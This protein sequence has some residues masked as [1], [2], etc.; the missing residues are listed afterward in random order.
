MPT[1]SRLENEVDKTMPQRINEILNALCENRLRSLDLADVGFPGMDVGQVENAPKPALFRGRPTGHVVYPSM[2]THLA[3]SPSGRYVVSAIDSSHS[4]EIASERAKICLWDVNTAQCLKILKGHSVH[5]WGADGSWITFLPN[6]K[7]AFASGRRSITVWDLNDEHLESIPEDTDPVLPISGPT[8]SAF[9]L[10]ILPDG[11]LASGM[12]SGSIYI[13][14]VNSH[15]HV[16]TLGYRPVYVHPQGAFTPLPTPTAITALVVLPNNKLVSGSYDALIRVWDIPLGQ[17]ERV[18]TGH[19]GYINSLALLSNEQLA[20]ASHD[21]TVR[22]WDMKSGQCIHTSSGHT[23]A[24]QSIVA[25]PNARLLSTSYDKTFRVWDTTTGECLQ[26]TSYKGVSGGCQIALLPDGRFVSDSLV[27][28]PSISPHIPIICIWPEVSLFYAAFLAALK[29]NTSLLTL[30]NHQMV[31][32]ERQCQ[33]L[34]VL[35]KD[36]Q[37]AVESQKL[38]QCAKSADFNGVKIALERGAKLTVID[39]NHH[40][41]WN[42][43]HWAAHH[44]NIEMLN[45]IIASLSGDEIKKINE[46]T[47]KQNTLNPAGLQTSAHIAIA[48]DQL[49]AYWFLVDKGANINITDANELSAHDRYNEKL[50]NTPASTV[51]HWDDAHKVT[52][53]VWKSDIKGNGAVG[54][55]TLQTYCGGVNGNGI[56]ASFWPGDSQFL[57]P[58]VADVARKTGLPAPNGLKPGGVIGAFKPTFEKDCYAEEKEPEIVIDLYSLNVD[59]I[60]RAFLAFKADVE[61]KKIN[62]AAIPNIQKIMG[63]TQTSNCSG[64]V[65]LLLQNGGIFRIINPMSNIP[66]SGFVIGAI[67]GTYYTIRKNRDEGRDDVD[68]TAILC[69]GALGAVTEVA[70][71]FISSTIEGTGGIIVTPSGIA[72]LAQFAAVKEKQNKYVIKA[73]GRLRNHN[74]TVPLTHTT[75]TNFFT[76]RSEQQPFNLASA[77]AA[78]P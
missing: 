22:I 31:F 67:G 54:H 41:G 17:C 19:T 30:V 50:R 44:G 21:L 16:K 69:G 60:N 2:T 78:R 23:S 46:R 43:L 77:A 18:F 45:A 11:R 64:L 73:D 9:S 36:K 65:L 75:T 28:D 35:M 62:W 61:E 34:D 32:D 37:I 72:T 76:K 70:L 26:I 25:L 47:A 59:E 74:V 10:A 8:D 14:D 3:V 13:W 42:A 20:S 6:N 71:R 49:N 38:F 7:I 1:S 40:H 15:R 57:S 63:Y 58:K 5:V 51:L 27:R 4:S 29:Q 24:V 39:T 53:R 66:I 33:E 12:H 56:Y 52:I 68:A 55:A 48:A